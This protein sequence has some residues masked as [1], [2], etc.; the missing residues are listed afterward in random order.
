MRS[1]VKEMVSRFQ[2]YACV[3]FEDRN[4]LEQNLYI[5]LKT[6]YY[7]LLYNIHLPNPMLSAIQTKYQD[8]VE[9]T[10]KRCFLWKTAFKHV[11]MKTKFLILLFISEDG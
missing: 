9:L 3:V 8:I 5:H 11:L 2:A 7:R 4:R 1:I 10:K 6:A